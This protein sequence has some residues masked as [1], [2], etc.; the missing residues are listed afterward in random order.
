M[1][2]GKWFGVLVV[3]ALLGGGW[4]VRKATGDWGWISFGMIAVAV[5]VSLIVLP[6]S[7]QSD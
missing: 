1:T 5:L 2:G 3:L 4:W 6:K 7:E